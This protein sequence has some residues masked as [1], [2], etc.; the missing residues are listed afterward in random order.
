MQG[1]KDFIMRGNVVEL[2]VAVVVGVTVGGAASKPQLSPDRAD[3]DGFVV[4]SISSASS[5]TGSVG[6]PGAAATPTLIRRSPP[7]SP[8]TSIVFSV[9]RS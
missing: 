8:H 9:G 3:Q 2:A 4:T 6:S 5:S 1:F 7:T